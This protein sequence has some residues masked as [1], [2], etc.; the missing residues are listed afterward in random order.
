LWAQNWLWLNRPPCGAVEAHTTPPTPATLADSPLGESTH[1]PFGPFK[2]AGTRISTDYTARAVFVRILPEPAL[3]LIRVHFWC[4]MP[5]RDDFRQFRRK[6]DFHRTLDLSEW[7]SAF[8]KAEHDAPHHIAIAIARRVHR[9][10]R[11]AD[12]CA[13]DM[14]SNGAPPSLPPYQHN[15]NV[16]RLCRT[17]GSLGSKQSR[18]VK[19]C[20][21]CIRKKKITL[22][23]GGGEGAGAGA[24]GGST[25]RFCH[26]HGGVVQ[27]EVRVT[28]THMLESAWFQPCVS[29]FQAFAVQI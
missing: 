25:V 23:G 14:T 5:L 28:V 10:R 8:R 2:R 15:G 3:I 29:W 17:P 27:V 22:G 18:H 21:G 24:G 9:G 19:I 6:A 12:G 1:A 7:K 13:S 4:E 20:G 16:C 11:T 26:G